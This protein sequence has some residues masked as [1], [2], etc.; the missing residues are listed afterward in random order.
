MVI[1]HN[2]KRTWLTELLSP[3]M[4]SFGHD[5]VIKMSTPW[6]LLC[7]RTHMFLKDSI[8]SFMKVWCDDLSDSASVPLTYTTFN[9]EVVVNNPRLPAYK[10]L[11]VTKLFC[12]RTTHCVLFS[13]SEI[14]QHNSK[15]YQEWN[16]H[17]VVK[18]GGWLLATT[19][20]KMILKQ[21]YKGMA[22]YVWLEQRQ[23]RR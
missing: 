12:G 10:I 20:L 2:M 22:E 21:P 23:G 5:N 14:Q 4:M 16:Q 1:H 11:F 8:S 13:S 7:P 15:M 3:S 19:N 9:P 18:T 17:V 6:K